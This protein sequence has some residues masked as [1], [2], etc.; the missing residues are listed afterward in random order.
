MKL[1]TVI[2]QFDFDSLKLEINWINYNLSCIRFSISYL[3]ESYYKWIV[4][5]QPFRNSFE[6]EV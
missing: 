3:T 2:V 4:C 5:H 1:D 6:I